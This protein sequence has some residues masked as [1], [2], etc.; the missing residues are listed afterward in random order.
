MRDPFPVAAPLLRLQRN[1]RRFPA[2]APTKSNTCG[3]PAPPAAERQRPVTK[4][5]G[6]RASGTARSQRKN[7]ICGALVALKNTT[8]CTCD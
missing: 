2:P 3:R 1:P 7:Q 4:K 6:P 5:S 8:G